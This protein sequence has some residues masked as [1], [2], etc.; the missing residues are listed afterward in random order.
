MQSWRAEPKYKLLLENKR[1]LQGIQYT[2]LYWA[3]L[4]LYLNLLLG[5]GVNRNVEAILQSTSGLE[6]P[7]L[8]KL[9]RISVAVIDVKWSKSH[10]LEQKISLLVGKKEISKHV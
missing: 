1:T 8:N 9:M 3:C 4:R 10:P 5:K 2:K 6:D 7:F